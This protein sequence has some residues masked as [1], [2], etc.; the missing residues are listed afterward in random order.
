MKHSRCHHTR[1]RRESGGKTHDVRI[2]ESNQNGAIARLA[3]KIHQKVARLGRSERS[4]GYAR[5][6]NK[7]PEPT[8]GSVTP[9]AFVGVAESKPQ[10]ENRDAAR[11]A[12]VPAVAHL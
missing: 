6:P 5:S 9:R 1:H 8:A 10:T 11:G 12:P 3:Q 2:R 4:M 7:A